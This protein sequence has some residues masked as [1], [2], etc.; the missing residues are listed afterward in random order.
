MK[1]L[2][3]Y[4]TVVP[5]LF[6]V[7]IQPACN[8]TEC[9][10]RTGDVV[11]EERTVND[12]TTIMVSNNVEVV[13]RNDSSRTVIVEAGKNLV[14]SIKTVVEAG[15]LK[16]TNENTCNWARSFKSPVKVSV[17]GQ[18]VQNI[19]Q[20]GFNKIT[21]VDT[22]EVNELKISCTNSG[23]IDLKLKANHVHLFTS[24]ASYIRLAGSANTSLL[25]TN[26]LGEVLTENFKVQE[27]IVAHENINTVHVFP[28][29]SLNVTFGTQNSGNV[30]YYNTPDTI[31]IEGTGTGKAIKK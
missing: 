20:N 25:H 14:P 6:V 21:T 15:I 12:F 7:L 13:L 30:I 5:C 1:K 18:F 16:I 9:F 2:F 10:K 23:D 17:G 26:G 11:Q 31:N 3:L 8:P 22:L 29:K 27:L 19:E 4:L 24:S 28:V